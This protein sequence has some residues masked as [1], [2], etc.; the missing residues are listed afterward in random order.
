MDMLSKLYNN[1]SLSLVI[2][3]FS[4]IYYVYNS[5]F[6]NI[7]VN[8]SPKMHKIIT[9]M[10]IFAI[11]FGLGYY[12]IQ[13]YY[14][15]KEQQLKKNDI[16]EDFIDN[17]YN[18]NQNNNNN[19]NNLLLSGGGLTTAKNDN[20]DYNFISGLDKTNKQ[21]YVDKEMELYNYVNN[22]TNITP[23]YKVLSLNLPLEIKN[24]ILKKIKNMDNSLNPFAERDQKWIESFLKIPF[25]K[26]AQLPIKNADDNNEINLFF[27]DLKK[28]LNENLYGQEKTKMKIYELI[29]QWITNEHGNPPIIGLCGPP[30]IGKTSLIR[31]LAKVLNRPFAFINMGGLKDGSEIRGHSQTYVGSVWG[32]ITQILMEKQVMNPC[33][34]MDELDKIS[35]IN[36]NEISGVLMHLIDNSQNTTFHDSY[37][38]NIDMDLSKA[39]FI[40]SFNDKEQVNRI[41]LDRMT[42]IDMNGYNMEQKKKIVKDYSLPS[43]LK[44]VGLKDGQVSIDDK[45]IEYLVTKVCRSE[46]GMRDLI[47]KLEDIVG[48]INL[49][50]LLKD[51]DHEINELHSLFEKMEFPIKIDENLI[52]KVF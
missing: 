22:D 37:F 38:H 28:S 36:K 42:I 10:F 34:F 35:D 46:R 26:Y 3:M 31:N 51:E 18:G 6:N 39:I 17:T 32:K 29:A 23:K 8:L 25:D 14:D 5:Y 30:G 4:T 21:F 45:S 20:K 19:I 43:I 49:Y 41:L 2:S 7:G 50:K 33:I 47:H 48:K 13:Y 9:V 16:Y 52:N 1:D 44:N 27:K 15:E 12:G 11:F 40:F 24:Q